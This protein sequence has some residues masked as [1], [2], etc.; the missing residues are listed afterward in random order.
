MGTIRRIL[1]TNLKNYRKKRG[2]SQEKLAEKSEISVQTINAIEQ[3]RKWVSDSMIGKIS[4]A[5]AIEDYEL[6]LPDSYEGM[7]NIHDSGRL[8]IFKQDLKKHLDTVLD[9]Q[10]SAYVRQTKKVK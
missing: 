6:F 2:I 7:S 10:F 9:K 8:Q 1:S 3:C 5:L 4:K